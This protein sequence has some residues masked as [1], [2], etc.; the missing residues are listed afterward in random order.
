MAEVLVLA[1][2]TDSGEVKKVTLE[3]LTAESAVEASELPAVTDTEVADLE[4]SAG[5]I[6]EDPEWKQ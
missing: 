6:V 4:A 2:H 5:A 1:E 3:L